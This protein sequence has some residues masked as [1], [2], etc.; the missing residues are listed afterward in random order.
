MATCVI[1]MSH[2]WGDQEELLVWDVWLFG[3]QNCSFL[4]T[5]HKPT[6]LILEI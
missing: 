5:S 1:R 2:T 3:P 6:R 4:L